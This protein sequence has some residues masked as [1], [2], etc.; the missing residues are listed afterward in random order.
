LNKDNQVVEARSLLDKSEWQ[1]P[2][3]T[4]TAWAVR[5]LS[6]LDAD[7]VHAGGDD[8]LVKQETMSQ[9]NC[10]ESES[11]SG[12]EQGSATSLDQSSLCSKKMLTF[13][14]PGRVGLLNVRSLRA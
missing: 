11:L 14:Y 7:L 6:V 8:P 10:E 13:K 12:K 1:P 3:A 9:L 5:S 4:F 2:K